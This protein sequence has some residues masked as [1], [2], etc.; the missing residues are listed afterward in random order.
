MRKTTQLASGMIDGRDLLQVLL[1]KPGPGRS[2]N[3]PDRLANPSHRGGCGP[4]PG[5][6]C[7]RDAVTG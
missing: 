1:I 6:G 5:H 2:T 7:R 3:H 4:I